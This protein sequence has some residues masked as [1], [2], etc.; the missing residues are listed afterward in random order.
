MALNEIKNPWARKL[1]V[2]AAMAFLVVMGLVLATLEAVKLYFQDLYEVFPKAV[3]AWKGK[4][5]E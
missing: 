3:A 4:D 2:T 5:H 1:A